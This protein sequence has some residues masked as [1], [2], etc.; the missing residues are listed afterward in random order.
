VLSSFFQQNASL[1]LTDTLYV[2]AMIGHGVR[3]FYLERFPQ[4]RDHYDNHKAE[5][6]S[7]FYSAAPYEVA[8]ALVQGLQHLL[9]TREDELDMSSQS[10]DQVAGGQRLTPLSA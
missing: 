5:A 2:D 9:F 6:W 3:W 7:L 10:S 4:R 1:Q 8:R